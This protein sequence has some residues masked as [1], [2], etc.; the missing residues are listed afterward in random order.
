MT[1]TD[2]NDKESP[3]T[4]EHKI[5]ELEQEKIFLEEENTSLNK[6]TQELEKKTHYR[7]KRDG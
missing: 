1:G 3:T 6:K 4:D 2:A 5:N 7:K